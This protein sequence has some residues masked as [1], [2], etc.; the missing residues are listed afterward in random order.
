M[1]ALDPLVPGRPAPALFR[2]EPLAG[3]TLPEQ[4]GVRCFGEAE[5]KRSNFDPAKFEDRYETALLVMLKSKQ[6]GMPF[7]AEAPAPPPANV[8]QGTS[9]N[10]GHPSAAT[11]LPPND[12]GFVLASSS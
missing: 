1:L 6:A 10:S 8:V 12:F 2:I 4:I 9:K 7:K 5:P 3:K 11:E